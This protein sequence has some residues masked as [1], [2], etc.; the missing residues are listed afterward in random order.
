[1]ATTKINK[2]ITKCDS[3]V[4]KK[5]KKWDEVQ[6]SGPT[7][8]TREH[9]EKSVPACAEDHLSTRLVQQEPCWCQGYPTKLQLSMCVS[10]LK[11]FYW[12]KV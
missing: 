6:N 4:N 3:V 9:N 5:R 10:G 1:M 11:C 7:L 2:S 12:V 8:K